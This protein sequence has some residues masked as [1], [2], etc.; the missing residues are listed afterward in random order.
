MGQKGRMEV[1]QMDGGERVRVWERERES[2]T[3][4][5]REYCCD[6]LGTLLVQQLN[7]TLY[8]QHSKE[9]RIKV[10]KVILEKT[11]W[12]FFFLLFGNTGI[13]WSG[14]ETVLLRARC[15]ISDKHPLFNTSTQNLQNL[16]AKTKFSQHPYSHQ[17]THVLILQTKALTVKDNRPKDIPSPKRLCCKTIR[18]QK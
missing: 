11:R 9:K 7:V 8:L 5:E 14:N 17:P 18:I 10:Q 2:P 12:L 16:K 15:F 4:R 6:P 1:S 3:L 13:S